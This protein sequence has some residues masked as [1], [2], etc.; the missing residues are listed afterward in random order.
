M[1]VLSFVGAHLAA[2]LMRLGATGDR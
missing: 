2:V 1:L